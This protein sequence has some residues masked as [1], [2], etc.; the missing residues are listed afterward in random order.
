MSTGFRLSLHVNVKDPLNTFTFHTDESYELKII[1]PVERTIIYVINIT[2]NSYFGARHAFE[3]LSQLIN[4]D[5]ITHSL[6]TFTHAHVTDRPAYPYRGVM[7]DTARNWVGVDTIMEVIDGLSY[8]KLNVLHWHLTDTQSFPLQVEKSKNEEDLAYWEM[9]KWGSYSTD[10]IYSAKDIRDVVQYAIL[11]GVKV[12]PEI[13]APSH[14]NSGWKFLQ[15]KYPQ[16]G[17]LI[18]C[19]ASEFCDTPPCGQVKS[20]IVGN[21]VIID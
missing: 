5:E 4:Y 10:K 1:P 21:I 18:L 6:Q 3:T 19:E 7:I 16:L 12:L 2:A 8:N 11:R 17:K 20:S 14:V 13:E 15:T 9:A